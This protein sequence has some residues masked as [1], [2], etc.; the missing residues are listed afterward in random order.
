MTDPRAALEAIGRLPDSEID[1]ADA[2][3][4]LA[5]IDQPDADWQAARTHLSEL[6]RDGVTLSADIADGDFAAQADGLASLIAGRHR[7]SGE[8]VSYDDPLNANLLH[9]IQHR[10][11]LP[12]ALGIIWMHTAHAAGWQVHGIDF[13]GHFLVALSGRGTQLV[14]DVFDGGTQLEAPDLRRLIKRVA[15]AKAELQP[16]L[17]RP[18][19]RRAVLLRLQNNI[20]ERRLRAGDLTEALACAQD[21]LRI[22]PETASL[23]RETALINQRLNHLTAALRCFEQFLLLVPQGEAAN[24]ARTAMEELRSRLN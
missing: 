5:R 14:L 1:L 11:G 9:T 6:A 21:M 19:G 8:G 2:A 10:R 15:G 22:A 24:R 13:P 7:Y 20:K 18:M 23:W 4:Q 12:V 16:G 17:L 3:L